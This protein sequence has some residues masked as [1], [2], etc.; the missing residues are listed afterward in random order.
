ME[1]LVDTAKKDKKEIDK[2]SALFGIKYVCPF[3]SDRFVDFS[4]DIPLDF[5]IKSRDDESR[6]H[7]LREVALEVG[8]PKSAAL[9]A[10]KAFQ[11]SSGIHKAIK[12]LARKKG[13]T[14]MKAKISGL[15]SEMEAYIRNLRES[16]GKR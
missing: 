2:L 8:V 16:L 9:R 10:K 3:L 1:T 5:K 14:R 7:I 6:K 4:M 12:K 13:Y 15:R 11:Y